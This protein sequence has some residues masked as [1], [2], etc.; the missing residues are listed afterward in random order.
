MANSW[1]NAKS[2]QA[3]Q[4]DALQSLGTSP[5]YSV[6]HRGGCLSFFYTR[7]NPTVVSHWQLPYPTPG[8]TSWSRAVRP[9]SWINI[10]STHQLEFKVNSKN[11]FSVYS[12]ETSSFLYSNVCCFLLF[13]LFLVVSRVSAEPCT[14]RQGSTSEQHA[15]LLLFI[16]S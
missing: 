13:P 8:S 16:L 10:K 9:H 14:G 4:G 11:W 12:N 1:P 6:S 3:S 2:I 7:T 15:L 5:A